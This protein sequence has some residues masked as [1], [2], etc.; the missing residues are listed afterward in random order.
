MTYNIT[1]TLTGTALADL[2]YDLA[3]NGGFNIGFDPNCTY[4]SNVTTMSFTYTK[5]VPD[6]AVTVL[7]L[8]ASLLGLEIF[9]R[10]FAP[11]KNQA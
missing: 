11:A 6:T 7:L 1:G 3:H 8:G 9:R 2:N 10:K 5:S 4:Y